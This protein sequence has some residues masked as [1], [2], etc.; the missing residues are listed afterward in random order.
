MVKRQMHEQQNDRI[1]A[2]KDPLEIS[3][4]NDPII[5]SVFI[6]TRLS[7]H[8]KGKTAKMKAATKSIK[9]IQSLNYFP[10]KHLQNKI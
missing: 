5:T 8:L 6:V 1:R 9:A 3:T 7:L 2:E 4:Q 10:K